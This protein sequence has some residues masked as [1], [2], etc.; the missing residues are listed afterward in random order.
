MKTYIFYRTFSDFIFLSLVF[1]LKTSCFE[2]NINQLLIIKLRIEYA[3]TKNKITNKKK[4]VKFLIKVAKNQICCK[5][6]L[7]MRKTEA[8]IFF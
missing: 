1:F 8:C 5:H 6:N 4:I 7:N 2:K 3:M